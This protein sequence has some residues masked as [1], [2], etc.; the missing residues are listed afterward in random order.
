ML[1]AWMMLNPPWWTRRVLPQDLLSDVPRT[2]LCNHDPW[3]SV[4]CCWAHGVLQVALCFGRFANPRRF[5]THVLSLGSPACAGSAVLVREKKADLMLVGTDHHARLGS[6][7]LKVT[8][9]M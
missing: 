5:A 6:L 9:D 2:L 4:V 7:A 8:T 3:L 1:W